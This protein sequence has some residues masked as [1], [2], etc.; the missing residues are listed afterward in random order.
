LI[1]TPSSEPAAW[2]DLLTRENIVRSIVLC[3]GVG[4]HATNLLIVSTILPAA[5]DDIG[6]MAYFA[7]STTVYVVASIVG[8][9]SVPNF[10]VRAGIRHTYVGAAFLFVLGS[11][12]DALAP[13]MTSFLIGRTAQG[14]GGGMLVSLAYATI[15]RIFPERMW[16]LGI[17]MV[18]GVWG[19]ASLI[20]P[21]IGGVFAEF[22]SWR[23]AFWM[24]SVSAVAFAVLASLVLPPR[25]PRDP[26]DKIAAFP[27]RR[28][29]LL[30]FA[31]LAV[32]AGGLSGHPDYATLGVVVA[33]GALALL[34]RLDRRAAG[35]TN[36]S[37]LLPTRPYDPRTAVGGAYLT[38]GL[39]MAGYNS[40][41]YTPYI[42]RHLYGLGPLAAGYL[43]VVTAFFWTLAS[44]VTSTANEERRGTSIVLG[45]PSMIVGL[46]ALAGL[47]AMSTDSL[48]GIGLALAFVGTGIGLGWS[49]LGSL[50]MQSAPAAE[51]GLAA[52]SIATSQMI[53]TTFGSALVGLV[54]N[55]LDVPKLT[56]PES[57]TQAS[58]AMFAIFVVAP[59]AA[60]I[61]A[62]R[63]IVRQRAGAASP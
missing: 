44:L 31:A 63:L 26:E 17:S 55:V 51:K 2:K 35:A 24:I 23:G 27:W 3:G 41:I 53:A 16:A 32:S 15:R 30:A 46:V 62:W 36:S 10:I 19:V 29:G 11:L 43:W 37:R 9:A 13:D 50:A 20:G 22:G 59:S 40:L 7:W 54:A 56:D 60:W 57:L 47:L 34:L 61:V 18:S 1:V 6:G 52:S 42:F 58:A 8:S 5:V 28:L 38:M 12:I 45:P 48:I 49:H 39:L 25:R 21:F 33:V 14:L 4:L